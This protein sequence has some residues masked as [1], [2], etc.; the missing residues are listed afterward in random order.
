LLLAQVHNRLSE[1]LKRELP[2]VA[3]F[4][5]PTITALAQHLGG[6]EQETAPATS[7]IRRGQDRREAIRARMKS[8]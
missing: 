3:L 5:Y 8:K 4:K 7:H 1:L 6:A 2:I